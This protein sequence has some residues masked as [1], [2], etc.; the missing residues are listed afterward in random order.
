MTRDELLA[1]I[2]AAARTGAKELDLAGNDL[3]ELP[4]EIGQ[5]TQ[6][7]TLILAKDGDDGY[8]GNNLTNLPD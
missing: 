6:L 4:P 1:V 8:V 2:E 3:T 5:L 7:E